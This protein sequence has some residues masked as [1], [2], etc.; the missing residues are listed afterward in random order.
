MSDKVVLEGI[1]LEINDHIRYLDALRQLLNE[2]FP[3]LKSPIASLEHL[4]AHSADRRLPIERS[5]ASRVIP[6]PTEMAA[7]LIDREWYDSEDNEF[8]VLT[9]YLESRRLIGSIK[10]VSI[11]GAG[12]CR[13]GDYLASRETVRFV[14]CLDISW[15]ILY[16]G[17]SLIE[18]NNSFLPR[19][20]QASRL[21]YRVEGGST[22]T[23]TKKPASF[24]PP[25]TKE[26]QK[27]HYSVRDAFYADATIQSDLI[28]LPYL[29][30]H[31]D[32]PTMTTI[33]IRLCQHLYVGQELL[34]LMSC[35]PNRRNPSVVLDTLERCGFDL[36]HLELIELPYTASF[37]D[38]SHFRNIFN[39]LVVRAKRTREI[40]GKGI[41]IKVQERGFDA[42]GAEDWV[43]VRRADGTEIRITQDS[44]AI[45]ASLEEEHS[46]HELFE[47]LQKTW[48]RPRLEQT[49]GE[50]TAAG[51]VNLVIH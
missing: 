30:D 37:Y 24:K 25:A 8:D 6:Y 12:T 11:W 18:Q 43:K 45:L 15:L 3:Y 29:L 9:A 4:L 50:L 21:Y 46:Y 10:S 39:T 7:A 49:I 41:L 19:L 34:I 2:K 47:S 42:N 22:L 28:C 27:I 23:A 32:G 16:F 13:L 48:N 44:A 26:P 40:G 35:A 20:S 33:L 5:M 1:A 38:F 31:F 17:K 36:Q 51:L 14:H